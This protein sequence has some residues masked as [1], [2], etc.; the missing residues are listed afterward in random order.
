VARGG[1]ERGALSLSAPYFQGGNT[2]GKGSSVHF[3]HLGHDVF[4]RLT[5]QSHERTM[6]C[7][8]HR[9]SEALNERGGKG[10]GDSLFLRMGRGP[11]LSEVSIEGGMIDG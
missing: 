4:D 10:D 6:S 1:A 5:H 2:L 3:L 8:I 7:P 9:V 11:D